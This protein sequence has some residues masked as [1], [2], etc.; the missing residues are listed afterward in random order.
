[1]AFGHRAAVLERLTAADADLFVVKVE[2]THGI[3]K[4]QSAGARAMRE[5]ELLEKNRIHG[6]RVRWVANTAGREIAR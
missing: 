4:T 6:V 3:Y 5:Q 1:M 2:W